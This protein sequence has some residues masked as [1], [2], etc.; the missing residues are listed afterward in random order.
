MITVN[1]LV[2]LNVLIALTTPNAS[3]APTTPT[4]YTSHTAWKNALKT[5]KTYPFSLTL[6]QTSEAAYVP[7]K[8]HTHI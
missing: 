7:S 1:L 6:R 3:S 2:M 5:Q 4:N 8:K